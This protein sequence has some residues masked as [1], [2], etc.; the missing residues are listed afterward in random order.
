MKMQ[1]MP[2][3]PGDM[4]DKLIRNERGNKAMLFKHLN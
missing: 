2:C 1:A 4:V 3:L